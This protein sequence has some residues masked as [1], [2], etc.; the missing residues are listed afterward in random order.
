MSLQLF[1][2][3]AAL[4]PAAR[5]ALGLGGGIM[6]IFLIL[7]V[8]NAVG[9]RFDPFN[10]TGKRADRAETAAAVAS[11]DAAARGLEADGARHTT[12]RVEVTLKQQEAAYRVTADLS[13]AAWSAP[14]ATA[15][16]PPDR[17]ERLRAADVQLCTLAPELAGCSPA[18][19][20]DAGDGR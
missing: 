6:V 3:R 16:L 13:D 15:P 2:P 5:V 12:Q 11:D 14:D 10:L 7:T 1:P 9:F 18:A 17:A 20:G 19:R 8:L 4:P